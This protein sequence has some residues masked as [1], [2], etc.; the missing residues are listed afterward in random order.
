MSQLKVLVVGAS[1]AGPIAAY[2]LAKAGANI[3]IIERFPHLRTNG[4]SID[5]RTA[6]VTVMRKMLGMESAVRAKTT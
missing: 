6:G 4:Q 5:I 2:W 3:T 1:I